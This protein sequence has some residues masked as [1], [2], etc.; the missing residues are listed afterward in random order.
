MS[1]EC[2]FFLSVGFLVSAQR[3]FLLADERDDLA[4]LSCLN[5]TSLMSFACGCTLH[6]AVC[7]S[8]L[9]RLL[10]GGVG[11]ID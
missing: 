8:A 3:S 11:G 1:E 2:R 7:L 10:G 5:T 4:G 6:P 9:R